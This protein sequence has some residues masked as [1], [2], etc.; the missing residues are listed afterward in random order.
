MRGLD[1]WLEGEPEP[2]PELFVQKQR[3]SRRERP[4]A[5]CPV[6]I[7]KGEV[8]T[9][10]FQVCEGEPKSWDQHDWMCPGEREAQLAEAEA[11][12]AALE[13]AEAA[14]EACQGE[15]V[16]L[17]DAFFIAADFAYDAWRE[18]QR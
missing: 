3:K 11:E 14:R 12:S 8:Y 4:C 2:G 10:T 1:A 7:A 17:D 15:P 18:Q 13:A 5:Y 16:A 9:R 6:P